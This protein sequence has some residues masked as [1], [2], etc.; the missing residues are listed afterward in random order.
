RARGR[1]LAEFHQHLAGLSLFGQRE[2]WRRCEEILADPALDRLLAAHEKER[3]EDVNMLRWHADRARKRLAALE[4]NTFAGM[5]IHGD[6]TPWNLHF[7]NERLTGILDF[8]LAHWDHRV[9]DFA[10]SWRGTHDDVIYGYSEVS[11]LSAEEWELLTP[12]WWASLIEGACRD[13]ARGTWD[14]GWIMKHLIRRSPLMGPD[15]V[16]FP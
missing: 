3:H 7:V 8:E 12:M 14:D 15:A 11:R 9:A 2:G 13:L 6:F 10:L 1:L 16:E 4:P 5:I